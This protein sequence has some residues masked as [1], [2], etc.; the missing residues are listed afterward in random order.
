MT[1][2]VAQL[3]TYHVTI[4]WH[5][6]ISRADQVDSDALYPVDI[7]PEVTSSDDKSDRE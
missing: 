5:G 7:R 4:S 3:N 1:I 6:E 2:S